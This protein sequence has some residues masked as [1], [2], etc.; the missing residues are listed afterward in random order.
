MSA[1]SNHK[2]PPAIDRLTSWVKEHGQAV[3]GFLFV[4][5]RN[6][7][8]A[9]D[10][11]QE[12]F[13]RAWKHRESFQGQGK[14]RAYLLQIADRIAC[15]WSRDRT[16][17]QGEQIPFEDIPDPVGANQDPTAAIADEE[18]RRQLSQAIDLLSDN[19]RRTL[20]MRYFGQMEFHEIAR[21]L[22]LPTNTVLSHVRRGLVALR[23]ILEGKL[24]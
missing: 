13:V 17:T 3:F 1:N 24:V 15:D 20:A 5:T 8:I 12:V 21:I 11:S 4:R 2:L 9:E 6:R 18:T 16:N 10:L 23:R 22:E 14:D 19:Q 7:A